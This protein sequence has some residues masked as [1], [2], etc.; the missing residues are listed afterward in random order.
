MIQ[1]RVCDVKDVSPDGPIEADIVKY[2]ESASLEEFYQTPPER[3]LVSVAVCIKGSACPLGAGP[4]CD[5]DCGGCEIAAVKRTCAERGVA[6]RIDS[7]SDALFAFL[8]REAGR[9][10]WGIGVAC[11]YEISK[12][13]PVF[14]EKYR[15][16]QL[17]FPFS[18]LFC[19]AH[20]DWNKNSGNGKRDPIKIGRILDLLG[21]M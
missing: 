15:I 10:D 9:F 13:T 1:W 12:L 6:F 16:R 4:D 2:P 19:A 11:P 17:V 7:D 18:S 8:D 5:V 3:I 21:D 14:W 20:P